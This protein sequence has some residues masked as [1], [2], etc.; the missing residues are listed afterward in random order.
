MRGAVSSRTLRSATAS[1]TLPGLPAREYE[2]VQFQT[3]FAGMS[4]AVETVVLTR[5]ESG[6]KVIGYFIR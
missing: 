1:S 2:V 4:N 5:E 3:S 6:W